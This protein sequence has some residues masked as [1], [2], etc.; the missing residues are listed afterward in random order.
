MWTILMIPDLTNVVNELDKW[1]GATD[2]DREHTLNSYL[3]ELNTGIANCWTVSLCCQDSNS[4]SSTIT[5]H[6]VALLCH[7]S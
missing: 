7:T 3:P 1:S 5:L 6:I 4:F 2:N